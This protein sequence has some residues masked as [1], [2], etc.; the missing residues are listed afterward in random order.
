MIKLICRAMG[1]PDDHDRSFI[2]EKA[3]LEYIDIAVKHKHKNKLSTMFE[4]ANPVAID[5][6][7]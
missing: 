5:L 6:L 7:Q 1:T 4:K 2:T 3:A